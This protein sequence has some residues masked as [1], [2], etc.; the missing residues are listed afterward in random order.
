MDVLKPLMLVIEERK[1]TLKVLLQ[2]N[3]P[4]KLFI[5]KKIY[6][7]ILFNIAQNAVK[8]NKING[9]ILISISFKREKGRLLT[10]IEDTGIGIETN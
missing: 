4:N 7:A 10:T 3:V 5:E 2:A 9:K 8:F 1:L 6:C